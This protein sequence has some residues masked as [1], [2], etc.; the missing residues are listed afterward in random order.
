MYSCYPKKG[1]VSLSPFHITADIPLQ[2]DF[3]ILEVGGQDA[4][5]GL[6]LLALTLCLHLVRHAA[7]HLSPHA[8]QLLCTS[9]SLHNQ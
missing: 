2:L 9:H 4:E 7:L 6:C 5:F 1:P 8:L 3:F